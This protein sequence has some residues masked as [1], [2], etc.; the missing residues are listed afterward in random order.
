MTNKRNSVIY[1]GVSSDLQK[2]FYEHKNKLLDGFT[3]KCN[4]D[5][6]VHYETSGDSNDAIAREKQIKAGS[7]RKKLELIKSINPHFRDLYSEL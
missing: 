5:K 4:I 6:L 3:K 1:T 7:R 2:R